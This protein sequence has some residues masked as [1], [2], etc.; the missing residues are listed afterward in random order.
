[1]LP[2]QR[3]PQ[4]VIQ[5]TLWTAAGLLTIVA[6]ISGIMHTDHHRAYPRSVSKAMQ[7]LQEPNNTL[8]EIDTLSGSIAAA[9][10]LLAS[11]VS[12]QA[13]TAMTT[14]YNAHRPAAL[15]LEEDSELK[16]WNLTVH[17]MKEMYKRERAEIDS[18]MLWTTLILPQVKLARRAR[19][20]SYLTFGILFASLLAFVVQYIWKERRRRQEN[21]HPATGLA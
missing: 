9:A 18:P 3:K 5:L 12:A 17:Y 20:L 6:L 1:M 11:Q 16:L 8:A 19:C 4:P 15:P 7:I 14:F 13:A 10:P 21:Q 2:L